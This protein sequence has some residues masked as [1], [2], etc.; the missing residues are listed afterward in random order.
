MNKDIEAGT[1]DLRREVE[2]AIKTLSGQRL[3]TAADFLHYLQSL[4]T[5]DATEELTRIPRAVEAHKE[6]VAD[7]AAGRTTPVARLRRK[8]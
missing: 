1:S 8:Y 3:R 5:D 6:G 7:I 4:D 2:A